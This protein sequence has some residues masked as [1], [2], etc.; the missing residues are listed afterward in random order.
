MK[1]EIDIFNN[2]IKEIINKL[3]EMINIMN[4][5]YEIN[6]NII[7]NYEKKNRNYQVLQNIKQIN[8]NNEIYNKL[9]N[10]NKMTNIKDKL[11]NIIDFYNNINSD[12]IV[13]N[14]PIKENKEK[15]INK[16]KK[17]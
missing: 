17:N 9:K 2:N 16:I 15:L 3:N 13:K 10:I 6:N 5:Y 8:I 11:Y 7:N 14:E 1:K 12:E 4:I